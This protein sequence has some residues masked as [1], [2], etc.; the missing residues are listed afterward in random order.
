MNSLKVD[1]TYL[2]VNGSKAYISGYL[3]NEYYAYSGIVYM[4]DGGTQRC[5]WTPKGAF[6]RDRA[7]GDWP[8]DIVERIE[9]E[10]YPRP[11]DG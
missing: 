11:T 5:C 3:Y 8:L 4:K 7:L 9:D 10:A 1:G 6:Y 2:T